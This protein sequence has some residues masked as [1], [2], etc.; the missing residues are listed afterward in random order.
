MSVVGVT[1]ALAGVPQICRLVKRKTSGDVS[2]VL[3][4]IVCHG[5]AW[6]LGYG[7]YNSILSLIIT[8]VL[9]VLVSWLIIILCIRYR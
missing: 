6:W 4:L 9:C 5:Q 8:N 7:I 1:M 2:I 3:W